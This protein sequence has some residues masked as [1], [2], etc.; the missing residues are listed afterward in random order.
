MNFRSSFLK[1]IFRSS[2]LLFCLALP[3]ITDASLPRQSHEKLASVSGLEANHATDLPAPAI[4]GN[5]NATARQFRLDERGPGSRDFSVKMVWSPTRETALFAGANHGA[6][7]RLNDVWEY[8][9]A[10]NSWHLLYAP[11]PDRPY[12]GLGKNPQGVYAEAGILREARGG[13]AVRGHTWWGLAVD[14]KRDQLLWMNAWVGV[15]KAFEDLDL[16]PGDAYA[17]PPLWSFDPGTGKWRPVITE[18][19][20][21]EAGFG[22]ALTYVPDRDSFIWYIH[23]W[24]AAG[25]W[26]YFPGENRWRALLTRKALKQYRKKSRKAPGEELVMV[27]DA[28][29]NRL[30]AQQ[31]QSTFHFSFEDRQWQEMATD[32]PFGHDAR[33]PAWYMPERGQVILWHRRQHQ[34]WTY[35]PQTRHWQKLQPE[36]PAMPRAKGRL[37]YFDPKRGVFVIMARDRVWVYRPPAKE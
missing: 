13:P 35:D 27:H 2:G 1:L 20:Y 17:G 21:P 22:G 36:G 5:F 18:G 3:A 29:G 19:P 28:A 32:G 11:D 7:H 24:K 30:I 14:E 23:N 12:S 26:E 25:L 10:K 31:G 33:S 4:T 6:P 15:D 9:L 37:G 8:S 16:D 34:L